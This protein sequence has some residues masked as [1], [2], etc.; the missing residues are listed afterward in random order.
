MIYTKNRDK[1][2]NFKNI[3]IKEANADESNRTVSGYL[4]AFGNIDLDQDIIMPGAFIKSITDHGPQSESAQ[5]IIY[6]YMHNMSEPIG[7]FKVLEEDETGLYFEADIDE[8]ELGNRVL[9]QYASGTINQHSIGFNYVWDKCNWEMV[10]DKEAFVCHELKLFEGSPVSIGANENTPFLG[11]KDNGEAI[12][13]Q[14]RAEINAAMKNNNQLALK[15]AFEKYAAAF[16]NMNKI[17]K[18]HKR[19]TFDLSNEI[20]NYKF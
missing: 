12:T 11:F 2:I 20:K 16:D 3:P 1:L 13:K 9:K 10:G 18:D 4:A 8:I 7:Q 14:L 15:I 17:I 6:L 19:P 5:K